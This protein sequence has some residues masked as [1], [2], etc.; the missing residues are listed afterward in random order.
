MMRVYNFDTDKFYSLADGW[1][2]REEESTPMTKPD[3]LA[4][5]SLLKRYQSGLLIVAYPGN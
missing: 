5:V 2:A 4:L 1:V 3:A